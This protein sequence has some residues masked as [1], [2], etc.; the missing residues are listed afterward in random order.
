MNE[1]P[2][3]GLVVDSQDHVSN[4]NARALRGSWGFSGRSVQVL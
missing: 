3:K 1:A 2:L 4:S